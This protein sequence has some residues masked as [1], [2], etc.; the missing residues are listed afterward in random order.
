MIYKGKKLESTLIEVIFTKKSNLTIGGR[1]PCMDICTFNGHYLNPLLEN[2]SK[3]ANKT[4]AFLG[5]FNTDF[6]NFDASDKINTFLDDLA[7][8]SL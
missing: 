8:N 4:I 1:H 3:E 7:S 5:D 6:L 2:L